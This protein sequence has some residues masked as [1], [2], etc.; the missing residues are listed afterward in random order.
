MTVLHL[1]SKL[2]IP[3]DIVTETLAI[4]GIRG[5]GKTNTA[6]VLAEELLAA[7]QQVVVID[8]TDVWWGLQ[9]S[10]D[11]KGPG[12][13]VIVLGG[14]KAQLPLGPTD[15]PAIA[16]VV[17]DHNASLILALRHFSSK[18]DMR[19]FITDFAERLYYRKGQL[20]T[21]TPVMLIIDEAS[22][23]VPQNVMGE[24][25]RMVGAIQQLVRQ[26]RSS[27]IGVTLIDQRAASVN[28]DVLTQLE[29]LVCHR[30]TSP[31]DRKALKEWVQQHDE[32]DRGGQFLDSLA[33]LPKGTA[34]IWSPGTLDVFQKVGI[35]ERR[36]FDSSRTPKAGE[37]IQ[38]P[39]AIAPVG[40]EALR[41]QL[42][43]TIDENRANDPKELQKRIR[44]LEREADARGL[45]T[46][47][48]VQH[49]LKEEYER[50]RGDL[51]VEV[52][53]AVADEGARH[54]R[55]RKVLVGEL[56]IAR[57]EAGEIN[58]L[59][60]SLPER[61]DT[62]VARLD[63]ILEVEVEEGGWVKPAPAPD[64]APRS[65]TVL[66]R[67]PT[68][69]VWREAHEPGPQRPPLRARH[70]D[71]V[72]PKQNGDLSGPAQRILDALAFFEL[73]SNPSPLKK[74]VAAFVGV[75][76]ATGTW[77]ERMKELAVAG[78]IDSDK[79]TM[80][81]TDAGRRAADAST[82]PR[83][84]RE[85]HER[86]LDKVSQPA[87]KILRVLIDTYPDAIE[88]GALAAMVGVSPKTG[89]WS[90]RLSELRTPGLLEDVNKSEV[91]AAATLF[92]RGLR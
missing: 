74:A 46:D 68:K 24:N 30:T 48:A 15:G 66:S 47:A 31:Q 16:D 52:Q 55:Y 89:T 11:G 56:A 71:A 81:L 59:L 53:R 26:G 45:H 86:W 3:I 58:G 8:P 25:A 37:R 34:W 72:S 40:L 78:M 87:S 21:P 23:V 64:P 5:S 29:V 57:R 7:G 4:L 83:S 6:V 1:A 38:A 51:E 76:A 88:K 42:A 12:H 70:V 61:I 62:L 65:T 33:S 22:L 43:K 32:H 41:G 17:V 19:R 13:P 54:E 9:S 20:D 18:A 36:T 84:R 39:T 82:A 77:S 35:R 73:S 14:R 44:E 28:K 27:G 75:S 79:Q 2:A 60:H 91:R 80:R 49:L 85:L 69:P 92:P 63:G 67:E 90:E 50:G 10:K